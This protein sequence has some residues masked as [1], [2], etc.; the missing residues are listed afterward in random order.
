[1]DAPGAVVIG[2][3]VNGLGVVRALASRGVRTA[4]IRT[5]PYDIAHRSRWVVESRTV[6]DLEE[7]ADGL[8][9]VL[10]R[11]AGSWAGWALVP[12]IDEAL[13]AVQEH[14]ERLSSSYRIVA[15]SPDAIGH[16]LDKQLMMEAA[17]AVGVDTPH[18][19]GPAEPVTATRDD[20]RFPLVVKPLYHP[21]FVAR[22][23]SKLGIARDRNELARWIS[24]MG[25][26]EIPGLVMDLVPGPDSDI[27]AYCAYLDQGGAPV[28]GRLVRKLRQTP[29]GFGD[30]RVAE[31]V[32]ELPD[33][34]EAT[35]EI[36]RR[37]GLRGI[38]SAEFKRDLRDGRFRF[39]EINGRS[40]VY[41]GLLRRAGLDLTGLAWCEHM[42][43]G[44]PAEGPDWRGVWIHLH[45]DLL[46]STLENRRGQMGFAEFLAPYR[47]PKVEAVWSSRDPRPFAAQWSRSLNEGA[48]AVRRGRAAEFFERR[49]SR[50]RDLRPSV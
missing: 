1:M 6:G 37:M 24:E 34:R 19:Y 12:T 18:S 9:E 32:D 42:G 40:M 33:L 50:S 21:R 7:S 22:F 25:R 14:R 43:N 11:E 26:A 38:V 5:Q 2:G 13:A 23:R 8:A 35:V 27:Y 28:A 16:L 49:A 29:P 31:V 3:Y 36:A 48:Q 15:P 17:R 45:P 39:L 41:N 46:H 30:A 20:L 44:R 47:R 4:V 10:D